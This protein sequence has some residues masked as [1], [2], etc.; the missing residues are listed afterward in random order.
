VKNTGAAPLHP[1]SILELDLGRPTWR[2]ETVASGGSVPTVPLLW[3]PVSLQQIVIW[4]ATAGGTDDLTADGV[5]NTPVLVEDADFVDLGDEQVDILVDMALH[6]AA[7]KEAGPR[8][9]ATRPYYATF[10]QEAAKENGLLKA[11]QAYRRAAGLDTRR[12]MQPAQDAPNQL[13]VLIQ[14]TASGEES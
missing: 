6:V 8:W 11:N 5:S 1:T 13:T 10:L 14:Q 7:F 4:P 3:A 12:W 2:G 9:R